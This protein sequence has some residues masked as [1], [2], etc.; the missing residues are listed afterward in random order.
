LPGKIWGFFSVTPRPAALRA[1]APPVDRGPL[2]S[3]EQVAE[4]IGGVEPEWV[5]RN[6]PGKLALG[7]R[8]VRWYRD[9]VLTWIASRPNKAEPRPRHPCAEQGCRELAAGSR[10]YCPVHHKARL[11]I[12]SPGQ[13]NLGG[14]LAETS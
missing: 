5:R 4:L 13:P 14:P 7:Q 10:D 1:L 11:A 3:P 6:V 9:D 8:T 2:L 12:S